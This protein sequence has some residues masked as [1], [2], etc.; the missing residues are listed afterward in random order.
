M[1]TSLFTLHIPVTAARLTLASSDTIC[2]ITVLSPKQHTFFNL[3]RYEL[4]MLRINRCV[5]E[6]AQRAPAHEFFLV[7]PRAV[8]WIE[9][10]G[11]M[12]LDNRELLT[13]L[14]LT[15]Y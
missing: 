13:E 1:R 11:F 12:N 5:Y 3:Y 8:Y 14:H 7:L 6:Y 10:V 4:N 9:P 2:A 15:S